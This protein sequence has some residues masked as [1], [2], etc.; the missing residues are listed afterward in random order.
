[1][2]FSPKTLTI[3]IKS[4]LKDQTF[5]NDLKFIAQNITHLELNSKSEDV[6]YSCTAEYFGQILD[7][8]PNLE[9]INFSNVLFDSVQNR[10]IEIKSKKIKEI[11]CH[12]DTYNY[13]HKINFI[14]FP[15]NCLE[16]FKFSFTFNEINEENFF[17][18]SIEKFLANQKLLTIKKQDLTQK[19]KLKKNL[20]NLFKFEVWSEK[21]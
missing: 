1:M 7:E 16:H 10:I 12:T 14:H 11:I 13:M 9:S 21:A 6:Y 17:L 5:I 3:N 20:T 18:D 4:K 2:P 15:E 19:L 8:L